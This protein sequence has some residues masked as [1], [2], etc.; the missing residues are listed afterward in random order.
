MTRLTNKVALVIGGARGIGLGI[1]QRFAAEGAEVF[2]TGRRQ[3]DLD[4]ALEV[5]QEAHAIEADAGQLVD[6]RTVVETLRTQAGRIDVLVVNAG[7]SEAG[8]IEEISEGHFDRQMDLNVRSLLFAVQAALPLMG[9]GA[10]IVLIGS[11]ADQVG[12][13]GYGVYAASK[14]AVRSLART[15]TT[16]LAPRGIRVNVVSPGPI[17]TAM[18]AGI[19]DDVRA[20]LAAAIPLGRL[21]RADEVAAAALF[22]ASAESSFVAG[23]EL[24]V[25]G[26]LAQV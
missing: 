12:T 4:R 20:A 19:S 5:V 8:R 2:I 1:A 25:D 13:D 3:E 15:W 16:E 21:G 24:C 22:L 7:F 11:I 6:L 23:A 18:F 17:D 10:T 9:Q 14:A 26:G